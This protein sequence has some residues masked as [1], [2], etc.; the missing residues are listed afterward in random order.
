[1]LHTH[2]KYLSE[3]YNNQHQ[4]EEYQKLTILGHSFGGWTTQRLLKYYHENP[5]IAVPIEKVLLSQTLSSF[6]DVANSNSSQATAY[7]FI[8]PFISQ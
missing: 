5:D 4:L 2:Q 6:R 3:H 7:K 1:M 8:S